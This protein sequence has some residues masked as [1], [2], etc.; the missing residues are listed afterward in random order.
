[1]VK[2]EDGKPSIKIE[3]VALKDHGDAYASE[4]SLK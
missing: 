4:C 3:D 1:V 2:G